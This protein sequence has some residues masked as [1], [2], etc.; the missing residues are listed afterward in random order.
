M[1]TITALQQLGFS[2]YEA[3]AYGALV[4]AGELN[5][6]GL[7]KKSGIPR[8][9][10]YAVAEKL[11]ARGALLRVE[12]ESGQR[13]VAVA[14]EQLLRKLAT[15]HKQALDAAQHTLTQGLT[16]HEPAPV[17]NLRG[18]E[19]LAKAADIIDDCHDSLLV[20]I[21]PADASALAQAMHRASDRNVRI[22]TLCLQACEGVCGGCQGSVHRYALAR[23]GS[24]RWL[25]LVADQ[26]IALVGQVGDNSAEG[27]TT[28]QQL[29]VELAADFIR[30]NLGLAAICQSLGQR[31]KELLPPQVLAQLNDLYPDGGFPAYLQALGRRAA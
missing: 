13:Y 14:P 30:Q 4:G 28:R 26:Q 15:E 8:A 24:L 9:N 5:G 1:D 3:R 25:V 11:L 17:F 6:Y 10:V 31:L 12:H 2:E 27:M 22:T 21:Q 29:V 7:A 23:G 19:L 20:A 18:N 16:R